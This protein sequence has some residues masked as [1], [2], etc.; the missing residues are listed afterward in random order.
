[1]PTEPVTVAHEGP[2]H[3]ELLTR[4]A[5]LAIE[6][7]DIVSLQHELLILLGEHLN[8]SRSYIFMH[9][10]EK[11]TMDNTAEWTAPGISPQMDELQNVP[12][13]GHTWWFER[14][15]RGEDIRFEDIEAIPD[16]TTREALRPQGI[17]AIL[18]VP[19]YIG[20]RYYGFMGFDECRYNRIW[21]DDER[22]LLASTVRILMAAWADVEMHGSEQ[23][24]R[25]ILENV[26]NVAVVGY[27]PSGVIHYW[28]LAAQ[29]LLGYSAEEAVG[30][31]ALDL[32]I[33]PED[34]DIT[35][36][37]FS[38][39]AN[40]SQTEPLRELELR[41]KNGT[42]THVLSSMVGTRVPGRSVELFSL[43][44]D[45][46]PIKRA[47]L[48]LIAT[49]TQLVHSQKM[50]GI[51]QLAAGVAHDFNNLL[52]VINGQCE[53][54]LSSLTLASPHEEMIQGIRKAGER[55]AGL[56]RQLLSFS[57]KQIVQPQV[58]DLNEVVR[59]SLKMLNR[60]IGE[61]VRVAVTIDPALGKVFADPG[62][63]GQV[64]MNLAVNA[65]DAM[66]TGGQLHIETKRVRLSQ[67]ETTSITAP[68]SGYYSLLTVSDTGSGMEQTTL[69]RI[70][71][72]FFTTKGVG[73]GTGLGLS[74]V[75]GI[76]KQAGG[77]TEV[78][79]EIGRGTTFKVYLPEV[80]ESPVENPIPIESTKPMMG[81]ETVL[82]VEDEDG[83]RRLARHM[84]TAHGYQVIEAAQG[85]EA[86]ISVEQNPGSIHLLITD[87][88]MPDMSG[89]TLADQV[90]SLD[91]N[92][93]ILFMSGYTDDAIVRHEIYLDRIHFLQ[94]PFT[95]SNLLTK[96]REAIDH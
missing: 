94:K 9:R 22:N 46:G 28:N 52:T 63:L 50:E 88:V 58:F 53:L 25:S 30:K 55:A 10:P 68:V 66:P 96:V 23:R 2:S 26:T 64:I 76:V 60:L 84:L 86:I 27:Y 32:F 65:R 70:F 37:I 85:K 43:D 11:N 35:Q 20:S 87:L 21:T 34:R 1:M 93:K 71:E 47:E 6:A 89:R 44:V 4:F 75:H 90:A 33:R 40:T 8:V 78:H 73:K 15:R 18:V 39:V 38:R 12:A 51:G 31:N 49:Q 61:D 5:K 80:K 24:F 16:E 19:L 57:R 48:E 69:D 81:S 79:S 92:I 7:N 29:S 83:V 72:P 62:Q 14:M 42:T 3:D 54:L 95:M 36:E 41:H 67:E 82:L 74:V 59:D 91:P 77:H 13:E 56:T 45:I 17:R